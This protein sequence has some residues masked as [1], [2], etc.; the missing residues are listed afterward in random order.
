MSEP[1]RGPAL[2]LRA[3]GDP[4][5]VRTL[6][7]AAW[8]R[9]QS[10]ARRNAVLAYLAQRIEAAGLLDEV[11]ERPRA[12]FAAARVAARRLAQLARWELRQLARTLVPRAIPL[13]AL[14]GVAYL[15]RGL[16][17]ADTRLLSDVDVMVPR[18]SLETAEA[19]LLDA[20]WRGTHLHPYDQRY[21]RE[22][23]HELPPLHYPGLLIGVDVHHTSCP[24]VSR[25]RPDPA[26][27]WARAE[28]TSDAG[29][30][31][32][33]PA[34][35]LLHAAVHLFFDSDFDG[36]FRDL[37][38]LHEMT[39]AFAGAPGF[40]DEACTRAAELGLGRPLH[41][42][43]VLLARILQTPIPG[44]VLERTRRCAA[45]APVDAVMTRM[46]DAV[47]RPIDPQDWPR[48]H[49]ATLWLLYARS[50]WLRMPPHLLV[51]HLLRK[52]L[53]RAPPALEAQA[54]PG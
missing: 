3:I 22:W 30:R 21:Y 4:G 20:G 53:R 35:A 48:P 49:R 45:P 17:H 10:C 9:L 29:V 23:S 12:A 42:T 25:L 50:H 1:A 26:A 40:L 6:D 18:E 24:P 33:A 54:P 14:K 19:A 16:P 28:A 7:L 27:F 34:D 13:I 47:L 46:L 51:P 39:L 36:R 32:L 43:L 11:P 41:Y 2:L 15:L 5:S 52:S 38:D 8:E 31:M 44:A 37:V